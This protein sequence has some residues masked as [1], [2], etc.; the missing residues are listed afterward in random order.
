MIIFGVVGGVI[1]V[2]VIFMI[3]FKKFDF[4][5]I[6]NGILVGLVSVIVGCGNLILMGFWVVG[7]VGGIIVVFF[8]VV[9]DVVGIDDFVGVFFVYGVCGV[10]GMIV[11][12]FW[13]YDV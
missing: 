13:G 4:I 8:V 9:F 6:I 10:W 2:M 12:G 1:G 5:M 11:I 7:L 3:I